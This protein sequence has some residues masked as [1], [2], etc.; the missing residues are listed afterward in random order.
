MHR[1]I[2]AE[3]LLYPLSGLMARE[4]GPI[5]TIVLERCGESESFPP[6]E[7]L[8]YTQHSLGLGTELIITG[9]IFTF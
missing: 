7:V 6:N 9:A 2:S 8:T 3:P 4:K 1:V 5:G